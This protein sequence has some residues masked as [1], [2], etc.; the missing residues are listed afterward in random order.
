[1]SKDIGS[2]NTYFDFDA[3]YR[4]DHP[5][6]MTPV[7][8]IGEPQ[9][10]LAALIAENRIHGEVLDVGCGE[11]AIDLVLAEL[12]Y[13]CVGLDISTTAVNLARAAAAR[14]GLSDKAE[15]AVADICDF[16]GYDDRF[17][18]IVD[19]TLFCSI[20]PEIRPGYQQSIARAAAPGA[21]YFALAANKAA[22]PEFLGSK[23]QGLHAVTDDELRDTVSPY[24]IVDEI[25]P[26][27]M[28]GV[29][30]DLTAVP[31]I[32]AEY[33]QTLEQ[34]EKGRIK[35]PAWRLAAHLR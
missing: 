24:W 27:A 19:S 20:P 4:D 23:G 12:G 18:T 29:M 9:P 1:M 13:H 32:L 10:E 17:N 26:A 16:V 11:G 34:D 22:I 8:S 21:S 33:L 14:A 5:Y 31:T 6:G 2:A 3:T 28:Y 35:T 7:W 30:P 15:F 25:A